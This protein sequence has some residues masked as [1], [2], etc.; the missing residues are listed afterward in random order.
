MPHLRVKD[1]DL[2]G[3]SG[4]VLYGIL[5]AANKLVDPDVVKCVVRTYNQWL[6]D[7]CKAAPGRFAGVG[8]ISGGTPEESAQ[9][10]RRIAT[11]GPERRGTGA[12]R[13]YVAALAQ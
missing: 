8:C 3:V 7:F 11:L 13:R 6:S 9:E 5:G 4:E 2:D 10:I 1:Q 12:C